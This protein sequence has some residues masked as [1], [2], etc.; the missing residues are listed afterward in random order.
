[1][2]RV[3]NRYRVALVIEGG[4]SRGMFSAGMCL[5]LEEL[6]EVVVATHGLAVHLLRRH[7]DPVDLEHELVAM[8]AVLA[9]RVADKLLEGVDFDQFDWTASHVAPAARAPAWH[10]SAAIRKR[11]LIRYGSQRRRS[12][13]DLRGPDTDKFGEWSI[14]R[15]YA[16]LRGIPPNKR[17]TGAP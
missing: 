6:G 4:D 14:S 5:G 7:V 1:V 16:S 13:A 9:D 3:P 8:E 2:Y 15:S 17:H 10:S 11:V 12:R